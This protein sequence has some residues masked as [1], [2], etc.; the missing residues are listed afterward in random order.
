MKY[1]KGGEIDVPALEKRVEEQIKEAPWRN[2]LKL[3]AKQCYERLKPKVKEFQ[4]KIGKEPFNV[5]PEDCD[6]RLLAYNTC[7]TTEAF[8]VR[9]FDNFICE[10]I[11][12]SLNRN[13]LKMIGLRTRCVQ[14]QGNG[15]KIVEKMLLS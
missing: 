4:M 6:G 1:A 2:I 5:K 8:L 14:K 11:L 13:A 9:S 7:E 10:I 15:S 12:K 3:I